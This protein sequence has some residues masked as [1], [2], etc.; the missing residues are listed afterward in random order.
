M[1]W[2]KDLH[3][4][5]L[6]LNYIIIHLYF[7]IRPNPFLYVHYYN[8]FIVV[9]GCDT[10]KLLWTLTYLMQLTHTELSFIWK[11][12]KHFNFIYFSILRNFESFFHLEW[13]DNDGRSKMG[14]KSRPYIYEIRNIRSIV[15]L[16]LVSFAIVPP[17]PL[18]FTVR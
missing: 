4:Q 1:S 9:I 13:K 18:Q 15:C 16:P 11:I 7:L 5:S 6:L 14:Q 2:M 8:N 3:H 17:T 10:I 12:G